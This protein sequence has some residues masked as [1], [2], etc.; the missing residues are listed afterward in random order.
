EALTLCCW[1]PVRHHRQAAQPHT[2]R[3]KYRV[4]NR[5]RQAHNRGL[6]SASRRQIFA[7]DQ[8]DFDQRSVSESWNTIL[9]KVRVQNASIVEADGFKE[10]ATNRLHDCALNLITQTIR[11][12]YCSALER[13]NYTADL[14]VACGAIDLHLGA[15]AEIPAFL[16][17]A[18]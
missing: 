15:R 9:C 5:R 16:E 18:G 2:G 17:A 7:V 8:H 11:V 6:S 1:Y 12:N 14:D 10:R 13:L 3:S 4:P